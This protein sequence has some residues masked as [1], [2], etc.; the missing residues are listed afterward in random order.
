[1]K[2]KKYKFGT[3]FLQK[4]EAGVHGLA[5]G[6][7]G[8]NAAMLGNLL[9]NINNNPELANSNKNTGRMYNMGGEVDNIPVEVEG[10][11]VART[12]DGATELIQG[13]DHEQ[14]GVETTYPEGTEIFSKRIIDPVT[15]K[16]MAQKEIEREIR[17]KRI[18]KK[19]GKPDNIISKKSYRKELGDLE[20]EREKD[21]SIME[22]VNTLQEFNQTQGLQEEVEPQMAAYGRKSLMGDPPG[23]TTPIATIA[24]PEEVEAYR[25]LTKRGTTGNPSF[26]KPVP[27]ITQHGYID[28]KTGQNVYPAPDEILKDSIV[29][30]SEKNLNTSSN[31][32]DD[33]DLED[34]DTMNNP[35]KYDLTTGDKLGIGSMLFGNV[36]GL[37]ATVANRAGTKAPKNWYKDMYADSLTETGRMEGQ[38]ESSKLQSAKDI[39]ESVNSS[40]NALQSSTRSINTLRALKGKNLTTKIE[41]LAKN[42]EVYNNAKNQLKQMKLQIQ[43]ARELARAKGE[44]NK[45][46]IEQQQRDNYYTNLSQD[47]ANMASSGTGIAKVLNQNRYNER[48]LNTLNSSLG[49][50]QMGQEGNI[51]NIGEGIIKNKSIIDN[52]FEDDD[53]ILTEDSYADYDFIDGHYYPKT[54]KKK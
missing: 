12:P 14:G 34:D 19:Y 43:Q 49:N 50:I 17:E 30:P 45:Y 54:K 9:Y 25:E 15:G 18:K 52:E 36:A 6:V 5:Q 38:L 40:D 4:N 26:Y 1:M 27:N 23:K 35:Q 42:N 16:T 46:N 29:T 11:E 2:T 13:A 22:Y 47:F 51:M 48:F 31:L 28:K 24:T 39:I 44:E 53:E 33:I 32:K 10:G 7:I 37:A 8:L 3:D 20:I 21:L 41:G